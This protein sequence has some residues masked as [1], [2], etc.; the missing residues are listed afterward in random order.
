M[1]IDGHQRLLMDYVA[2]IGGKDPRLHSDGL[3][4][5]DL[6]GVPSKVRV[7]EGG[8]RI[9]GA[10]TIEHIDDVNAAWSWIGSQP[11]PPT[12]ELAA[13]E[14]EPPRHVR[15]V[16]SLEGS[17]SWHD[18]ASTRASCVSALFAW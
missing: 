12:S 15:R 9:R 1:E 14:S 4:Q 11:N 18:P 16:D 13:W 6:D 2:A 8:A 5:F 17:L 3:V 10:A 7:K